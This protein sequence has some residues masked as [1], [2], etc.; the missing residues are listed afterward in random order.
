MS[1]IYISE[2]TPHV[3]IVATKSSDVGP[4]VSDFFLQ[5]SE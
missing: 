1:V 2:I 3:R 5:V 4:Q